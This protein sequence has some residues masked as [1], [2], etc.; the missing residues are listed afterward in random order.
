MRP[1]FTVSGSRCALRPGCEDI[2]C[3]FGKGAILTCKTASHIGLCF[4]RYDG[5]WRISHNGAI[6]ARCFLLPYALSVSSS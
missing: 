6:L 3:L 4:G 2:P 1:L 5:F